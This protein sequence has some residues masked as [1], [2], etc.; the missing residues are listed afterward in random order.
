ME[1]IKKRKVI[2]NK[3]LLSDNDINVFA[4]EAG[5]SI[6]FSLPPLNDR[7]FNPVIGNLLSKLGIIQTSE[8]K[9]LQNIKELE[10]EEKEKFLNSL[11]EE[12]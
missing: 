7:T 3:C 12:K 9:R 8:E 6:Y 4:K 2:L 1:G 5:I 11:K 10:K